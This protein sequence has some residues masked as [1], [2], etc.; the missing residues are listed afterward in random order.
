MEVRLATATL[1]AALLHAP[2][3]AAP[4]LLYGAGTLNDG[5]GAFSAGEPFSVSIAYDDSASPSYVESGIAF[6]PPVREIDFMVNGVSF[7]ARATFNTVYD[8]NRSTLYFTTP[9]DYAL[10]T[11]VTLDVGRAN[12]AD[13]SLP[14]SAEIVG[15]P[16]LF[17]FSYPA[18]VPSGGSGTFI[19]QAAGLPEPSVLALFAMGLTATTLLRRRGA[20][21]RRRAR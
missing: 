5:F 12:H 10:R 2:A 14:T 17:S 21:A 6:Y 9:G 7:V 13:L 4:V 8:P 18:L 3:I 11:N 19:D 20:S 16:G 15:R 1:A